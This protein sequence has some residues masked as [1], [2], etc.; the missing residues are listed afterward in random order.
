MTT[1]TTL[2]PG[3]AERQLPPA[4]AKLLAESPVPHLDSQCF[5]PW[6][7]VPG[8]KGRDVRA[9]LRLT[10]SALYVERARGPAIGGWYEAVKALYATG[11]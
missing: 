10:N 3:S 1:C 5:F 6:F 2:P 9:M 11:K 7:E 8:C 4:P